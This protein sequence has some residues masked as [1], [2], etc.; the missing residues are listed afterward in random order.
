MPRDQEVKA[1]AKIIAK[2][3]MIDAPKLKWPCWCGLARAVLE[4]AEI[5]RSGFREPERLG[6]MDW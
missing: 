6:G 4:A 1:A 5:A 3:P 2:S